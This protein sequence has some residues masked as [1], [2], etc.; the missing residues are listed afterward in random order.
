MEDAAGVVRRIILLWCE[1]I[2]PPCPPSLSSSLVYFWL[3]A[4]CVS[5]CVCRCPFLSPH[6]HCRFTKQETRGETFG[7][8]A[9]YCCHDAQ[10]GAQGGRVLLKWRV[11]PCM[12]V[13]LIMLCLH[14]VHSVSEVVPHP[15][16]TSTHPELHAEQ[17]HNSRNN[18]SNN[19]NTKKQEEDLERLHIHAD[20]SSPR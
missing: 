20:P 18:N 13:C 3:A 7:I 14:K 5:V 17:Q 2:I 12:S 6:T 4:V 8:F 1:V 15:P 11:W 16:L 9:F 10:T 19:M